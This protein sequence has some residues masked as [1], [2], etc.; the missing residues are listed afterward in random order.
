MSK[1]K[2]MIVAAHP[3]DEVLGCG[4][5]IARLV[6]EGYEAYTL[7][8]GKGVAARY[9]TAGGT[10][11]KNKH[12]AML[13]HETQKANKALGIKKVYSFNVP[14]NKFDSVPLLDI[15]KKIEQVKK[16][17][18]PDIIF[19]HY[20]KDLN[21]DHKIT[22]EAVITA[23]RPLENESVKTI[24]SFEVLSSTEWNY[25]LSFSPAVFFDISSSL[26]KK[27]QAMSCY[28][29]EI[30]EFPHPRSLKAIEINAK[31][32]GIKVGLSTA[33]AFE[34]VRSII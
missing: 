32:W 26:Q 11:E 34:L 19:T 4:G 9:P 16:N 29:S 6:E 7:I 24:Y 25:P 21:I 14:D 17:V 23:S 1:K 28:A 22:Y 10:T 12:I 13:Q 31:T 20:K 33:E 18:R 8:L 2:I 30:R 15:V 3:D 5:T 27:I